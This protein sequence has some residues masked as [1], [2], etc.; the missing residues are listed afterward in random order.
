MKT[1]TPLSTISYNTPPFLAYQLNEYVRAKKLVIAHWIYHEP[2]DEVPDSVHAHV[3]AEP[4]GT[5]ETDDLREDLVEEN[6]EC[7]Y[8]PFGCL[9]WRK[10]KFEDWYLYSC[11]NPG[12]LRKKGIETQKREYHL[13]DFQ[14][15][16]LATLRLQINSQINYA[17]YGITDISCDS[18]MDIIA[19]AGKCGISLSTAVLNPRVKMRA[20]ALNNTQKYLAARRT[21]V[22]ESMLAG[23]GITPGHPEF[24]ERKESL[25]MKIEG[26][27]R[28]IDEALQAQSV[29]NELDDIAA[30]RQERNFAKNEDIE[31]EQRELDERYPF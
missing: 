26:T 16:S 8:M 30:A 31:R 4:D 15:T 28:C 6:P 20:G 9:P 18:A 11:H 5:I 2:D 12:Y 19:N 23:Y 17:R 24:L 10:T 27:G 14:S 29:Q 25:L 7:P 22:V 21:Q 13:S 3:Y 1:R